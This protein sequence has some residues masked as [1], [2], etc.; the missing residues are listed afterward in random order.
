MLITSPAS[1]FERRSVALRL[2]IA[3]AVLVKNRISGLTVGKFQTLI[4]LI[5]V[6]IECGL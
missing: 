2:A 6:V 4:R 1:A 5:Y 3:V